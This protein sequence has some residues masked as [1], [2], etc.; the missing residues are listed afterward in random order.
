MNHSGSRANTTNTRIRKRALLGRLTN[1]RASTASP[2]EVDDQG[3]IQM[4]NVIPKP[5]QRPHPP[6][7]QAFSL[8]EETVRWC[9]REGIRPTIILPQPEVVRKL[10]EAYVEEAHNA[11]RTLKLGQNIGVLRGIYL[12]DN[13]VQA[14]KLATAG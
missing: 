1:G 8:S 6:L 4:I 10:G 12:A 2:G 5:Y 7:F 11:G 14:R 9:A 13:V 3:R